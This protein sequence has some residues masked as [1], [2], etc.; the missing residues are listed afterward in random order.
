MKSVT[1][2]RLLT[3]LDNIGEWHCRINGRN[4]DV[5][6]ALATH[7]LQIAVSEAVG[8]P[9]PLVGAKVGLELTVLEV[10][11]DPAAFE[12]LQKEWLHNID[13]KTAKED[14]VY[15]IQEAHD[16][17]GIEPESVELPDGYTIQYP[18][19][20]EC[21]LP[22]IESDLEELRR[23]KN[24]ILAFFMDY[25]DRSGT[26]LWRQEFGETRDRW[27]REP[28]RFLLNAETQ[29]ADWCDL[30]V[31]SETEVWF[32]AGKGLDP[33]SRGVGVTFCAS[34]REPS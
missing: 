17:S 11:K 5:M 22:W 9:D 4:C 23:H 33:V 12:A 8:K 18:Y 29:M 20:S 19:Y 24:R 14:Q 31:F 26:Q 28:D 2:E 1:K 10:R 7:G 21:A 30:C 15:K 25:L 3:T 27:I 13:R 32:R 16:I 34:D 6:G